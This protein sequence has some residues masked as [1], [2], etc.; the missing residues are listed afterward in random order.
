M[1]ALKLIRLAE[2]PLVMYSGGKDSA[3]I[4]HLLSRVHKKF[5]IFH[6][7]YGEAL[8]P[9]RYEREAILMLRDLV[10]RSD[11]LV[12]LAKRPRARKAREDF[13]IG[14]RAFWGK[15]RQVIRTFGV[16]SVVSSL[17]AE[18]SVKRAIKTRKEFSFDIEGLPTFYPIRDWSWLDVFAYLAANRLP[19]H[20]HY[21]LRGPLEGWDEVR[22][23]TFFDKEFEYLGTTLVDGVTMPWFRWADLSRNWR[24]K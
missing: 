13:R 18:E 21:D 1:R 24:I 11:P 22:F 6:W 20:S 4:V 9:R 16:R 2:R 19:W 5:V 10:G 17:R 7:D 8:M 14:Y 12:V 3:V 15:V 23:V